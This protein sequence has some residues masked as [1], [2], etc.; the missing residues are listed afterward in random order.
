MAV[1]AVPRHFTEHSDTFGPHES[2]AEA[3]PAPGLYTVTA[4]VPVA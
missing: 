4:G 3:L 1:A 2:T